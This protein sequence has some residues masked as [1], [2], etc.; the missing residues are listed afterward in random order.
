MQKLNIICLFLT[1]YIS[2]DKNEFFKSHISELTALNLAR[3]SRSDLKPF[4]IPKISEHFE[5]YKKDTLRY[6]AHTGG[7]IDDYIYTNSLEALDSNYAKGFRLFELDIIKTSDNKFVAAHY[8][9]DWQKMTGCTKT[10]PI[11]HQEFMSYKL[12]NTYMPLDKEAVNHWFASHPD[13]ILITDKINEPKTF[14]Q[15]FIV[16]ERLI[17]ELF[18]WE[19][20][21]ETKANNITAM[22][23]QSVL[24]N[25]KGNKIETLNKHNIKHIALSRIVIA[26][27][28][29]LL[30]TLKAN[31]IKVYAYNIND[32][33]DRDELYVVK[34]EL[35]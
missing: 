5:T 25:I 3:F 18:T 10:V 23:S 24:F 26:S 32:Y 4:I 9:E 2:G 33:I 35:N 27:N 30:K 1:N 29:E 20:V 16:P 12:Y 11:T 6:I 34:H 28:I 14:A 7:K 31:G 13:A 22:P 8:W 15:Q 17:M 21:L 19:G